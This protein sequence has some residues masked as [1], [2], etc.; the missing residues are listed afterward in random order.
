MKFKLAYKEMQDCSSKVSDS[1]DRM[2]ETRENFKSETDR[3]VN[4][5]KTFDRNKV[6]I[7]KSTL[8]SVVDTH[9]EFECS[10]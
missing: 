8:M 2:C 9:H 3:M 7:F 5:I 6:E 4:E 10:I 1:L